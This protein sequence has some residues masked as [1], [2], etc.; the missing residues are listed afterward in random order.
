MPSLDEIREAQRQ[1]WDKFSAGWE[2][3]DDYV[4]TFL[5][6][7]GDTMI[8]A[9]DIRDDTSHLD[10]AAGTGEPGLTIAAMAPKGRTVITD[11][12]PGMLEV[13]SKHAAQRGLSNVEIKEASA[14]ALPFDDAS[15]DSVT[16]RF[17]FMFFPDVQACANEVSRVV[18][19]GGKVAASVW[20]A[21]DGNPW[22][23]IPLRNTMGEL[24]IDPPP[25]DAP[26]MFRC[27]AP[28]Y[29]TK[30]FEAAG[31]RDIEEIEVT[32]TQPPR[33]LEDSWNMMTDVAA[34]IAGA[35]ANAT[36]EQVE[37]IRTKTLDD[38]RQYEKD[39]KTAVPFHSRVIVGT[40]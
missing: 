36:P 31:L 29:V 9:L 33:A 8:N 5:R 14:D 18:K 4:L 23:A 39:G 28:G 16:I 22:V 37:R 12:A 7:T 30:L 32:G 21:P 15:F 3:W 1:S 13:A 40:K 34:P 11:L 10:V 27:A 19:P 35:L 2:K 17:G 38:L 20:A 6:P 24:G 26:G 25:P